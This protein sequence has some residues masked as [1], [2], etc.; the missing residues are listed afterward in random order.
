MPITKSEYAKSC[1]LNKDSRFRKDPAYMLYLLWQKELRELA[2]GVYNLL[3]STGQPRLP[4]GQ[5]MSRVSESDP[6]VE[7]NLS[8]IFQQICGTK[9][10]WYLRASDLKCMLRE[11]GPPTLFLT[12]SCAE[13][14]SADISGYLRKV[15]NVPD[16]Y[17]IGKLCCE[18][19]ISIS[20]KFSKK[21]Y[22]F[23]TTVIMKGHV[24]G[25]VSQYFVKKE[26]QARGAPHYHMVLW[27]EGAPTIGK[28]VPAGVLKWT[29]ERISCRI[30]DEATNPE[31]HRLVT[32]TR[33][34]NAARTASAQR[35]SAKLSSPD[36][37][38]ASRARRPRI[39]P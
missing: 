11:C 6:N 24:L 3:K 33:C 26:Y 20:R 22:D 13:Y 36:A 37:N 17:P 27:I 30:P 1:L 25:T 15:N 12:F 34:T 23:F 29:Q 19:P 35:K 16:S 18:D 31:L 5:F 8:T 39:V 38:S 10:F 2:S 4:I 28:D 14:Q 7:A 32:G 9:Q 21:F